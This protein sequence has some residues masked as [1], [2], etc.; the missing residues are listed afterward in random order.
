MRFFPELLEHPQ[1]LIDS[2]IQTLLLEQSQISRGNGDGFFIDIRTNDFL[3][4]L[5]V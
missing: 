5:S 2:F 4:V 3:N 1:E